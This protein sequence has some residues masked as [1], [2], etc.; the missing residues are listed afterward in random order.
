MAKIKIKILIL[1]CAKV[2]VFAFSEH[3]LWTSK[4]RNIRT[5]CHRY[6]FSESRRNNSF[7]QFC[8]FY[9]RVLNFPPAPVSFFADW[10]S[11]VVDPGN[12]SSTQVALLG[13]SSGSL[14]LLLL[15]LDWS[16]LRASY[17]LGPDFAIVLDW[18]SWS[19]NYLRWT[20]VPEPNC[21]GILMAP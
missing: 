5:D 10:F 14:W 20:H 19:K 17:C 18:K 3:F 16:N 2:F 11:V 15:L 13:Y 4:K 9:V 21:I 7:D 1:L 12:D 6:R 8:H